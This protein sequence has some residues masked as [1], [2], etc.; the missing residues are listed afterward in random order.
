MT[1]VQ[2]DDE[3]TRFGD[4]GVEGFAGFGQPAYPAAAV[5]VNE[6]GGFLGGLAVAAVVDVEIKSF[7]VVVVTNVPLR[8]YEA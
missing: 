4:F 7:V 1:V 2:R 6:Y 8:L 5:Y 3:I